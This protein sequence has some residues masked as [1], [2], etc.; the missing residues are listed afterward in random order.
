[1]PHGAG[2]ARKRQRPHA[3][4]G[5]IGEAGARDGGRWEPRVGSSP[6]A[7]MRPS[8]AFMYAQPLRSRASARQALRRNSSETT[9]QRGGP[10][11]V[12]IPSLCPL[13]K[14]C[15]FEALTFIW[16]L[17]RIVPIHVSAAR[18]LTRCQLSYSPLT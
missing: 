5:K 17:V 4:T 8:S 15:C 14:S 1:M 6:T 9:A 11:D 13:M 2:A 12:P 7:V 18:G 3:G 10:L 16:F